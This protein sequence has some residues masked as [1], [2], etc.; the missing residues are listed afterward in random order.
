MCSKL[1]HQQ[2]AID[3]ERETKKQSVKAKFTSMRKKWEENEQLVS[4]DAARAGALTLT[5][6]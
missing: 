3:K 5:S 2:D 1:Q 4:P 6:C